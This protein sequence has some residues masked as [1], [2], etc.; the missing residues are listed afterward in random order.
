LDWFAGRYGNDSNIAWLDNID[1]GKHQRDK[2][3]LALRVGQLY[4]QRGLQQVV[5][6]HVKLA[7]AWELIQSLENLLDDIADRLFG[8]LMPGRA[9]A[10]RS[11]SF[12]LVVTGPI[13]A[14]DQFLVT[15]YDMVSIP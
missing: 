5:F 14:I 8:S 15:W 11:K 13:P 6:I 10:R 12:R 9:P 4:A 7:H 2:Q 1:S 3:G